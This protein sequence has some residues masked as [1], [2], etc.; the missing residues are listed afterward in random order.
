MRVTYTPK[1]DQPHSYDFDPKDLA[2]SRASTLE[3]KFAALSGVPVGTLDLLCMTA[4]QG[5]AAAQRVIAWHCEST[6]HG[7]LKLD[8]FDPRYGEVEVHADAEDLRALRDSVT[9]NKSFT[10]GQRDTM[11]AAI[12]GMV[13]AS[14][15]VEGTVVDGTFTEEGER[16]KALS[17][18]SDET[19]G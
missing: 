1:G 11:L 2:M 7:G 15:V 5:G 18:S 4:I 9:S 10:E 14:A 19:S 16:G 13:A 12:D 8:D 3:A 17:P 6:V